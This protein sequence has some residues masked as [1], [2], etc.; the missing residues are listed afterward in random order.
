MNN[1]PV[2]VLR[3]SLAEE[4]ANSVTHGVG[5]ALSIA[6]L[7]VLVAWAALHGGALAVTAASVFGTT[8]ILV[9]T[10]STLYHAIPIAAAAPVLRALDHIAIFLLI[11]GTYTP[12]TLLALPPA[13]GWSLFTAIWALAI[14][15]IVME[16]A[17]PRQGRKLPAAFYVAMGWLAVVAIVPLKASLPTS[18]FALLLAGGVAYTF[19]VPFYLL[20]RMRWHHAVWHVFVLAGS[21]LQ[22]F[23]VL[24]YV[25]PGAH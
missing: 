1:H 9:Y 16:L 22:Y 21:V 24:L 8:L 3:G 25:V 10:A 19:G 18:G 23:A 12:F 14:A 15:G 20:H 13:W 17:C 6:G 4:V 11:A 5:I 7:V 2:A